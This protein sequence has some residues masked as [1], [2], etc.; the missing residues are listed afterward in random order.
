MGRRDAYATAR[1]DAGA[2]AGSFISLNQGGKGGQPVMKRMHPAYVL[3]QLPRFFWLAN[4]S[5]G[6]QND[7]MAGDRVY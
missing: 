5:A 4:P 1:D 7:R 2:G 3:T 6:A